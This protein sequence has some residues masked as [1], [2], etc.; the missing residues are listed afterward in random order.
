MTEHLLQSKKDKQIIR[1]EMKQK[2]DALTEEEREIESRKIMNQLQSQSWYKKE[3]DILCTYVSYKSEV[4]TNSLIEQAWTDK[5]QVCVPRVEL[6]KMQFY[7]ITAWEDLKIGSMG[8]KEPK[9]SCTCFQ[10]LA[11]DK[12]VIMILPGLAF[13][14]FGNRIGYGKGFYDRYLS[15]MSSFLPKERVKLVAFAY[16]FQVIQERLPTESTDQTYDYLITPNKFIHIK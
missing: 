12:K 4:K 5:K 9:Q 2:R 11:A 10:D 16:S 15:K 6:D 13:D 3:C 8:I 14:V 7:Y 1:R